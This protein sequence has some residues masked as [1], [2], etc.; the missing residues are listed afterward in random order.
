MTLIK[1]LPARERPRERL[2]EFGASSLSDS[3]IL[4]LVLGTGSGRENAV[5]VA[6]AIIEESGGLRGVA[7]RGL[8][9]LRRVN[10]IGEAKAARIVASVE[11]GIRIVENSGCGGGLRRF[12]CSVDIFE[13][14]RARLG[15][16]RQE[17]FVAVGLNS[18]N[19]PIEEKVVA[20]GSVNE[21]RVEPSD[22]FRPM[23][24][25][26]AVRTV[27]LHNHP[28]GDSTPSPHDVALTRRLVKVGQLVGIPVLDHLV[29]G[30]NSYSSLRDLGLLCD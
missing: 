22:V 3:E 6:R 14:Y 30:S 13:S 11:L 20:R 8:G 26:A 23:I 5:E 29:L 24:A 9:E 7:K 21:C 19:E 15:L 4:G 18:K 27:L 28:S 16:L 2:R 10:G 1:K 25:E 12:E 17:V